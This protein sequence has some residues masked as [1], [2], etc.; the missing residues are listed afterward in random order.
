MSLFGYVLRTV[1]VRILAAGLVVLA[2]LQVLDLLEIT[3]EIIE[4]GLGAAGMAKYALLRAPRL[5][6]QAA[7]LAVLAGSIFAFMKLASE[8][9]IVAIRASGV[10]IYRLATMCAPAA[11][12]V[13]VVNFVAVQ[14]IA[15]RTDPILQTWWTATAPKD[16]APKREPQAFRVGADVVVATPIDSEGRTLSAVRIYRR[17]DQGRLIERIDSDSATFVR[18]G[19]WRLVNPRFVRFLKSGVRRGE[20][21]HMTWASSFEPRDVRAVFSKEPEVS[22]LSAARA[23]SGGGAERPPSFY[24]THL[25]RSFAHPA[26]ALVMLLLAAPVALANFRS[27]QGGTFVVGSL[28]AGLTFLVA[29]GV[30]TAMGESGAVA[31]ILAAWTGPAVF[32]ALGATALLRL[33]G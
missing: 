6:D 2:I 28:V 3:T 21:G 12:A 7:P 19:G 17:D 16:E 24:E 9:Q 23:L 31:P 18:G 25:Q 27:G 22:A 15:P 14:V 20:A 13:M 5:I 32:A 1:A 33:E 10:S 29:D 30:L 8:S 4:R 11:I 26:G